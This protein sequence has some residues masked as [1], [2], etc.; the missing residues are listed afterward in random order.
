MGVNTMLLRLLTTTVVAQFE[1]Y[2]SYI[3]EIGSISSIATD[4]SRLK[5]V[6]TASM[7]KPL[8]QGEFLGSWKMSTKAVSW[9]T[10]V[11]AC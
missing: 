11:V 5:N 4:L 6:M 9:D 8:Q 3:R 10:V 1:G 2:S 7:P